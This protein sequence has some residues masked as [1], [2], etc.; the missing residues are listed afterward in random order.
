MLQIEIMGVGG[1]R[2]NE[3]AKL[4][5]VILDRWKVEARVSYNS[6]IEDI[7]FSKV[8]EI[9]ALFVNNKKVSIAKGFDELHIEELILNMSNKNKIMKN[10]LVPTDL[11]AVAGNAYKYALQWANEMNGKINALHVYRPSANSTRPLM[12]ITPEQHKGVYPKRFMESF[13]DQST[14]GLSSEVV[15]SVPVEYELEL[16]YPANIIKQRSTKYDLIIMGKKGKNNLSEKLFGGVT[17]TVAASTRCPLLIVPEG[18]AYKAVKRILYATSEESLDDVPI[19]YVVG[20]AE[21]FHAQVHFVQVKEEKNKAYKVQDSLFEQVFEDGKEPAVLIE[22]VTVAD[23][24]ME[25]AISRYVEENK[26]DLI[27]M[28]SHRKTLF[29]K[30]FLQSHTRN[31]TYQTKIPLLV[32]HP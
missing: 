3:L 13:V 5:N 22:I 7:L 11:S 20:L 28:Y 24:S 15:A 30:L 9:P 10:I 29:E 12:Q 2:Q 27:V 32:M 4:L 14:A 21:Q 31:L 18:L 23:T 19:D 8:D 26:I 16:G 25:H 17:T 1:T 6:N